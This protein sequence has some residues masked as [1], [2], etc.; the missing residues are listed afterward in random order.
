MSGGR[1]GS[2]RPRVN[3]AHCWWFIL[4]RAC[5]T[6]AAMLFKGNSSKLELLIEK[7]QSNKENTTTHDLKGQF[8]FANNCDFYSACVFP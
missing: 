1:R 7:I 4:A 2:R 5:A 6:R 8:L 3:L